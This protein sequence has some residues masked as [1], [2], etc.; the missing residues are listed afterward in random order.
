MTVC[1]AVSDQKLPDFF[2]TYTP[3]EGVSQV[4]MAVED[5]INH[6]KGQGEGD[7]KEG[8]ALGQKE[9]DEKPHQEDGGIVKEG[10][11]REEYFLESGWCSCGIGLGPLEGQFAQIVRIGDCQILAGSSLSALK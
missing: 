10:R 6:A 2:V 5:R 1:E 11:A 8:Y 3:D 9:G 7:A 4:M